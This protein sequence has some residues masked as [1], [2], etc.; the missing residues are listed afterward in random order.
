[1]CKLQVLKKCNG[2][3][4][5]AGGLVSEVFVGCLHFVF[6]PFALWYDL[7]LGKS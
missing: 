5:V 3:G 7:R 2:H 1:M 6:L 4:P